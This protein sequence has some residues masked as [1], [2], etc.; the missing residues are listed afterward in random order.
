MLEP[1]RNSSLGSS[2]G[3]TLI[4]GKECMVLSA[5][6]LNFPTNLKLSPNQRFILFKKDKFTDK[7]P[8]LAPSPPHTL[9]V[10]AGWCH[11]SL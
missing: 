4:L 1:E 6:Y 2:Q 8:I 5:L 11:S 9:Q 10:D 7:S 3:E